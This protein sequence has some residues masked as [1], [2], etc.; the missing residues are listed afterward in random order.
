MLIVEIRANHQKILK[1]TAVN[2]ETVRYG[3]GVQEYRLNNGKIIKHN[4]GDGAVELAIK[5]LQNTLDHQN[6]VPPGVSQWREMGEKYG[7]FD[8][9]KIKIP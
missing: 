2:Q 3:N 6:K 9:F 1:I 8:Y 4:Y 7:Y 5:M